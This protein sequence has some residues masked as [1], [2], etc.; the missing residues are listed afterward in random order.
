MGPGGMNAA[1]YARRQD[2][3]TLVIGELKGGQ[4]T[5]AHKV[6]NYMGFEEI[7]GLDLAEKFFLHMKNLGTDV[8]F[9]KV[10]DVKK[11]KDHFKVVLSN[12]DEIEGK[13]IIFATGAKRRKLN[14]IGE[15]KFL[16][17]GVSYCAT[18]DAAFFKDKIVAVVGGGNSALTAALLLSEYAKLVY[19]IHRR[20]EFRAEKAWIDE[21]NRSSK[22][23]KVLNEEVKEIKGKFV[24]E[25]VVLKSGKEINVNGIFIE[26]GTIPNNE[27][28]LKL[29]VN[30]DKKRYV[31]VNEKQQTNIKGIYAIGDLTGGLMQIITA[32]SEGAIAATN[33]YEELKSEGKI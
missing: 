25:S 30:V 31:K 7:N 6:C 32:A 17:R 29:G 22:I 13:K 12:N 11:Y 23:K 4:I 20:N 28:C 5:Y 24:V 33:V 18:C 26:I 19:L 9:S 3:K 14:V 21:V 2:L 16:G 1:I 15:D 10:K 8:I 27:L